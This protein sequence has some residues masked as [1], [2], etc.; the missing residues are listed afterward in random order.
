MS[1]QSPDNKNSSHEDAWYPPKQKDLFILKQLVSKDFKLKYR[2]SALGVVWSVLN[3]L[4]MMLV[5]AAVFGSFMRYNDPSIGN[6]AVYLILGNT[7]WQ[8][9][10][11]STSQGMSSII[12]ASSLLKK[13]KIN[14]YVFPIQKVLFGGVNYAFSLIAIALVM[15]VEGVPLT[16]YALLLPL[17]LLLLMIFCA[18]LSLFLSA[19]SVF[20]RDVIH[21]WSVVLTAWMYATPLFYPYSI[22]PHWMQVMEKFNPMYLY[23]TFIRDIMLWDTAPTVG[24]IFG[25]AL[26]AVLALVIG[27]LVFKKNEHKFI[28]YI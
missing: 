28:L 20:F 10:S 15:L 26:S 5:M 13:V 21:L 2:R 24:L 19:A 8:L 22:L 7:A 18:G 23:V 17:A 1:Q 6:Y 9:M 12:G 3:P 27:V 14:R 11:D 16:P 4:L 25:C